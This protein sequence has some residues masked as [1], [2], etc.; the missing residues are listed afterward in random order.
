MEEQEKITIIEG[1]PPTFELVNDLWLAGLTEGP[2]ASRIVLCRLRTFNGAALVERC[3]RAWKNRQPINLEFR[4]EEGL[5]QQA[6]IIAARWVE[7]AEGQMLMLWIRM[8]DG[9]VEVEID[10]EADD[11]D[12]DFDDPDD[13][14]SGL[15]S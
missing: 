11:L 10:F 1:P 4:S 8:A 5:T 12:D 9:E 3:Y 6:P 15:L 14:A 2:F 7:L 13:P